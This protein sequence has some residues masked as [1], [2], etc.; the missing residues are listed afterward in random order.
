MR[1]EG[2]YR[3]D[4]YATI[5]GLI[6]PEVAANLFRQ[7]QI[8]LEAA[9]KNFDTFAKEHQLSNRHTVDISGH[10]LPATDDV[11]VGDDADYE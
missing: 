1:I 8:D 6:P 7:I 10:F 2:N 9:G 11:S 3:E 5:R 4:G